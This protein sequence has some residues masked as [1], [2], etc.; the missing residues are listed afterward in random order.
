M[1][2]NI[3]ELVAVFRETES[4]DSRG[5]LFR[6]VALAIEDEMTTGAVTKESVIEC[7]GPPDKFDEDVFVYFFDH[8]QAGGNNDEWYFPFDGRRFANSGYN[9]RG[10]N[11]L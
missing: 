8:E 2:P 4:D 6:P 3:A 9:L 5:P 10:V 7:F 11:D 1:T